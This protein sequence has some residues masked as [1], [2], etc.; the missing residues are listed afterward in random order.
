MKKKSKKNELARIEEILALM[1]RHEVVE[2]EW[3]RAGERI[4]LRTGV[5]P[6]QNFIAPQKEV[7]HVAAP[8]V[9]KTPSN[10][11]HIVSP[12]VGTF[13]AAPSPDASPY[14][15]IGKKIAPGDTL[16]I[17]EAMKLMNQIE[18]EISGTVIAVLA[19]NG[20][21]IEYGESLFVV[22]I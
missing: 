21:P 22:E 18:S 9:E 13:Y 2:F 10:H 6:V 7:L 14:V 19:E 20:Q 17:V 16:C 4:A 3:E 11:K 15:R 5:R 8:Q 12:F 1:E